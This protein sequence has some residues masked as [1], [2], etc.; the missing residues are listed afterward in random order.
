MEFYDL[1][2]LPTSWGDF[3]LGPVLLLPTGTRSEVGGGKWTIGPAIGLNTGTGNW[4]LGILSLSYFS[5]AGDSSSP[6]VAKIKLQPIINY[7]LRRGWSIGTSQMNFTYD[8]IKGRST[9]I[10]LGLSL[11]KNFELFGQRLKL[12]A[13]SEYNFV[14]ASGASAWTFRFTLEYLLPGRE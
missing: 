14:N 3:D 8:W 10:P 2:E 5:F 13:E 9:N 11:G 12:S 4:R 1:A 7:S 6:S